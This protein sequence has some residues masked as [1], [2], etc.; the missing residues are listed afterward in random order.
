MLLDWPSESYAWTTFSCGLHGCNTNNNMFESREG[1]FITERVMLVSSAFA[2]HGA[3][4][5]VT[6]FL[7]E[8]SLLIS[9]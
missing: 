9:S 7:K 1:V 5:G 6:V 3:S 2:L 4:S 8:N